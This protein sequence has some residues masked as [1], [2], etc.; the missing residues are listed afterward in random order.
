LIALKQNIKKDL[1]WYLLGSF[2]PMAFLLVRS[3]IYTRIFTTEQYGTYSIV[4]ITF[5]YISALSYQTITNSAWRYYLKYK[6]SN[7]IRL[8]QTVVIS[9][10]LAFFGILIIGC[11]I[12]F[13]LTQD[14]FLRK[15]ILFGFLFAFTNELFNTLYVP[16]R[17]EGKAKQYNYISALREG[18]SF[19]LLLLLTFVFHLTIEAF[20]LAPLVI[21]MLFILPVVTSARYYSS[22][23]PWNRIRNHLLR[24]LKY[25]SANLFYN[26]A[27]F[28]L[29]SSDRFLIAHFEGYEKAG[30]YHQTYNLAQV[31]LGALLAVFSAALNP[32]VLS[33]LDKASGNSDAVL[34]KVFMLQLY[35]FIPFTII[36]SIFSKQIAYLLLGEAFR[37]AWMTL[38]VIAIGVLLNGLNY[39]PNAK[40]RFSN[41]IRPMII[42]ASIAA[43]VNIILNWIFIPRYG[44]MI[45]SGTTLLAYGI[46][47]VGLYYQSEIFLEKRGM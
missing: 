7:Q 3:P 38:P 21:N 35:I 37:E 15:L 33:S 29:I 31:S 13:V 22:I 36:L 27:L 20:L 19:G 32:T 17:L 42:I 14:T 45:A 24:F 28:L 40:L 18:L 6:R 41:N 34:R 12:W 4:L 1:I 11:S 26:L 25:G 9:L 5:T 47:F 10:Y 2:I 44:Y 46:L 43:L 39:L 23:I 8:Y 30:I 16:A